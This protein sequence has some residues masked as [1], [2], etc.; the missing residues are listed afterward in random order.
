MRRVVRRA[1]RRALRHGPARYLRPA[2]S[3]THLDPPLTPA[4]FVRHRE[5]LFVGVVALNLTLAGLAAFDGGSILLHVDE[6][7]AR[8]VAEQRT[9]WLTTLFDAASALGDNVVVFAAGAATAAV[10]WRRC[11][12][13]AGALV[14]AGAFRP[15]M[16]FVLKALIDRERPDIEPL[17]EFRGPSHPSGHP[18]AAAAFWGLVPAV[19]ALHVRSR[20]LWQAAVAVSLAIVA[21]VAF[22]R[23]YLGG[24]WLTDVTASIGW[25]TLYLIAVQGTF[26]RFHHDRDCRHSQHETQRPAAEAAPVR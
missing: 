3:L 7:V 12:Y 16:E 8:W 13:L 10:T 9:P 1:M 25:A 19:I 22:S 5:P 11:R 4:T 24:H 14:L 6:P 18:M 15:V 26:D 20:R 2:V 17:R 21:M 23:V